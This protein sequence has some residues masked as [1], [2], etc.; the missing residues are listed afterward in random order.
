MLQLQ[1]GFVN[2]PQTHTTASE[3]I[4]HTFLFCLYTAQKSQEEEKQVKTGMKEPGLTVIIAV[5]I[6]SV[7][8]ERGTGKMRTPL[9]CRSLQSVQLVRI[10]S[11]LYYLI[12]QPKDTSW[13]RYIFCPSILS[14]TLNCCCQL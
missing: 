6:T 9:K 1:E 14:T 4:R 12:A 13:A 2:A 8:T 7:G 10:P 3:T 5:I 11:S